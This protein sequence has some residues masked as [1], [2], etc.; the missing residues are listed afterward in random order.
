M[1]SLRAKT[2][3]GR[4]YFY[5]VESKRIAGKPRTVN[6]I[7]LGSLGRIR[8]VFEKMK[9]LGK[10]QA[11]FVRDFGAVCALLSI[12]SKL[13]AVEIVDASVPGGRQGAPVG[14]HMLVAAISRAAHPASRRKLEEWFEGTSLPGLLGIKGS[15]VTGKRFWDNMS[16]AEDEATLR[17]M[18]TGICGAVSASFGPHSRSIIYDLGIFV[19][20]IDTSPRTHLARKGHDRAKV[21]DLKQ[22]GLALMVSSDSHVPLLYEICPVNT[23]GPAKFHEVTLRLASRYSTCVRQQVDVTVVHDSK[24]VSRK[25]HEAL[26][27]SPYHFI[28]QLELSHHRDLLDVPLSDYTPLSGQEWEGMSYY[29]TRKVVF[30][31]EYTVVVVRS[32]ELLHDQLQDT[33]A[34]VRRAKEAIEELAASLL[35][36][37]EETTKR[38]RR[39]SRQ[40]VEKRVRRILTAG[41]VGELFV[42]RVVECGGDV[43]IS[44]AEDREAF[45]A[46]AERELGKRILFTDN[47]D[48]STEDIIRGY[49]GAQ[50]VRELVQKMKDPSFVSPAPTF[51]W[52]DGRARVHAFYCVLA[53]TLRSLL[54]R[55]IS[56]GGVDM[57][58]PAILRTLDDIKE[59]TILYP[60]IGTARPKVV[61]TLSHLEGDHKKLFEIL[62][63]ES[64]RSRSR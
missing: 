37:A 38:G 42:T 16:L 46:L 56:R 18:Q 26:R 15:A 34:N 24:I 22:M 62:H 48:W 7:Y 43:V 50:V 4:K 23:T 27:E 54:R 21:F 19:S 29:R 36:K 39:P 10:P 53:L 41:H 28:A 25:D 11:V 63:L 5:I 17:T 49:Y 20:Y 61:R 59:V 44:Y 12:G 40:S 1:A 32:D 58:I 47:R 8:D 13:G 57:N 64:W 2:I 30:G 52:T 31:Q 60:P 51:R 3:K 6:Q 33:W 45:T 9:K 14:M 35:K 55:E